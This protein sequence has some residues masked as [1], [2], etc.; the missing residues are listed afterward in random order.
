MEKI[1]LSWKDIEDAIESIAYKIEKSGIE[2]TCVCGV[3]RGG[4]IPAVL[5]SHK[6][7]IPY[8]TVVPPKNTGILLIDDI[9][10]SGETIIKLKNKYFSYN[11]GSIHIATL[12]YK[13]SAKSKPDFWY[14]LVQEKDWIV[15]PWE[16]K[17]SN[18]VQD[19]LT[20]KK[21][22]FNKDRKSVFD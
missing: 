9:C 10:D 12:H 7:K 4:L 16:V 18:T 3:E 19:Y 8:F 21:T 22:I 5:L 1:Y 14:S 17:D 20:K 15:Y 13:Q 11:S 6:M 2:I